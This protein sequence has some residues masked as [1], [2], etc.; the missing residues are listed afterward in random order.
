MSAPRKEMQHPSR[1][2]SRTTDM[3]RG[4]GRQGARV[5][6]RPRGT[7]SRNGTTVVRTACLMERVEEYEMRKALDVARPSS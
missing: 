4:F 2:S 1:D 6:N 7:L 5:E 3:P